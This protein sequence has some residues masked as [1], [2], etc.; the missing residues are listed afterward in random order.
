M[1]RTYKDKPYKMRFP[2]YSLESERV[3]YERDKSKV[4]YWYGESSAI[5]Y[6]YHDIPGI[7]PKKRK[8]ADTEWHWQRG[9]PSEWTRLMMNRPERRAAHLLERKALFLEAEEIDFPDTGRKPHVY[10]Y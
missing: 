6:W 7:K 8:E 4:R 1:S 3:P 9:T 10:Y 5:G 2:E